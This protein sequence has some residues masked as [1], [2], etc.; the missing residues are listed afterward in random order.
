MIYV[1][2]GDGKGKTTAAIGMG[3]RAVGADKEVLM[4]RFL[5]G[6]GVS[7]EEKIIGEIE[8]FSLKSFGR[9]GFFLPK[10][11]LE[12]NP[13][14][15]EKGVKPLSEKDKELFDEGISFAKDAINEDKY[16]LIILDEIFL[17]LEFGLIEEENLIDFL[18]KHKDLDI[19]LTGRHAPEDF[20]RFADLVTEMKEVK[21]PY[22][23]GK[24]ARKGIDY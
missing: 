17:G 2:T 13:E 4:V 14:L 10:S 16:D 18:E 11:E 19:A 1:F 21:H 6:S 3:L 22:Q 5:K 23:E 9:K 15:K 24:Q 7:S 20:F 12:K 8:N